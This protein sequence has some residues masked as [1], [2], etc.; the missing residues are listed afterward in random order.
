MKN[1]FETKDYK[2]TYLGHSAFQVE[3]KDYVFLFDYTGTVKWDMYEVIETPVDFEKLKDKKVYM[4]NSHD[5]FDHYDR[6]LHSRLDKQSNVLVILGCIKSN[7]SN[8]FVMYPRETKI[9]GDVKV[10]TADST[11]EGVCFLIELDGLIILH[12][13]D[14]ALWSEEDREKYIEEIDYL[15]SLNLI[16][17]IAFIPVCNFSAKRPEEMTEGA[18]YAIRKLNPKVVIPMHANGKEYVYTDFKE[19]ALSET[20]TNEIICMKREGE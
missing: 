6:D 16:P 12:G 15:T 4:F 8:T 2:V 17:D 10:Y 9:V 19:D 7:N 18:I 20:I 5:H 14:N 1:Y 11:D 13:G 3:Y